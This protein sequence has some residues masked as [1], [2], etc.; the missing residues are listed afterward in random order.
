VLAYDLALCHYQLGDR[1]KALEYL[2]QAKPGTVEPKQKEKLQYLLTHFTTGEPG[3]AAADNERDRIARVNQMAESLGVDA[4]LEDDEGSEEPFFEDDAGT[5]TPAAA[6]GNSAFAKRPAPNANSKAGHRA[7]LCNALAELKATQAKSAAATFDAANCAETNGRTAEAAAL[8]EK[9]L[10]MAPKALDAEEARARIDDLKALLTLAGRNGTEIRRLYAA[11]YTALAER[12]YDRALADFTAAANLA[13]DFPATPWK[14]GLYYEAT[15]DVEHARQ[16]FLRYQQLAP[17]PGAK[18]EAALHLSTL[19]AKR[20]KYDEEV[21]DAGDI[22]GDLLNRSLRLSFNGSEKRSALR[23]RRAQ[24]KKKNEQAKARNRVGGFA[25]PYAFAQQQL[26]E[27]ASHLQIALA[28]FPLGAEA[29]QLMGLVFLQA[30]DGRSAIKCF[31]VVASQGLPAAFYAELRGRKQDEAVKVELGRDGMRLI[32]LSS[33]DKR[34][35]PAPPRKP[36]GEDGLGLIAVDPLLPHPDDFDSLSLTPGQIQRVETDK[37]IIRVKMNDKEVSLSPIFLPTYTPVEGPQA[38][39]FANNYTRL[40]ARYPGLE[41]SKLGAEGMTG[42]EKFKMG[43]NLATAGLS[44]AANGFTVIGA[45]SSVTDAISIARTI[46]SA[47]VSLSVSFA[48]WEKTVNDQQQL[49]AGKAFKTIPL[50]AMS[51]EFAQEIK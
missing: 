16:N 18:D 25:I 27:A 14:L 42:G 3:F 29:N 11:A 43:Y 47:V 9:Y 38:R 2:G 39:R 20:T 51:L 33:Y 23:A 12:K 32:Y 40:F 10:E 6:P 7:S 36:A 21:D 26:G 50:Q 46:Q 22:L 24:V 35:N 5:D 19:D 4:F 13:P 45:I 48:S 49:L 30:N 37:G 17:S 15:G 41:N 44:I 31:D 28:L 8:L 34:G 1:A